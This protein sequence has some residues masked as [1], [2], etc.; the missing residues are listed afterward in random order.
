MEE[1]TG[2]LRMSLLEHLEELRARIIKALW[3]FGVIFLLCVVFS[4]K[5]FDGV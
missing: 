5:L 2:L 4:D 3:G 1:S